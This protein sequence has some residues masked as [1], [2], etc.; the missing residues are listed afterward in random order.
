MSGKVFGEI[1]SLGQFRYG[2]GM[3]GGIFY[4]EFLREL[5]GRRG[6]E[7]Y[8]E[9]SMNDEIIGGVLFAIEMLIRE[10]VWTVEEGGTSDADVRAAEFIKSCMHDME[11]T[12]TDFIS[13]VL[14][15]LTFGW[16]YHEIVYKRR[17]GKTGRVETQSKFD[18][19]LIGLRKLPIRS[20]DTLWGWDY[21]EK[22][23]LIG[24]IQCAPPHYEFVKIPIE[25]A[26]HFRTKSRKGNPEGRSIL[27][28]AYRSYYFKRRIQ[29]YEGIGIERDLA[30][31]PV[32]QPA[33]DTHFWDEITGAMTIQG[34]RALEIVKSVRRDEREGIVLPHG[35]DFK[36][37][38]SGG[39]R[40]FDTN[41]V[42]NRYD[43]RIAM[44]MLADFIMLGHEK[45]G[46]FALADA[47]MEQFGVALGAF[48]DTICEVFN[49][50]AIPKLIDLNAGAFEGITDY[51]KLVSG[52]IETP[53]LD[54]L[55]TFIKNTVMSGAVTPDENL[56]N[57]IRR[58]AGFP[59]IDQNTTYMDRDRTMDNEKDPTSDP[60]LGE[61]DD[62]PPEEP[63]EEV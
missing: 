4:E 20:Q 24:M 31:L 37:L 48:L 18:D 14:S 63:D 11:D 41:E 8:K 45:A 50:T 61:G 52:D 51:P 49:R 54:K 47:K 29:E 56:E 5:Q 9:M 27:R 35:W 7:V 44:S 16:S 40:Q 32:I 33:E 6:V 19:G 39:N 1:G 12:W 30:G 59:E 23:N 13:E 55:G 21:D 10:V 26:L 58:T 42:I 57:H 34:Q 3:Y 62:R 28:N 25:K 22:D 46:S 43:N 17:M 15:F 2:H 60:A 36:L 53:D 38:T